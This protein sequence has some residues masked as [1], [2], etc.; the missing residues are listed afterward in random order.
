MHAARFRSLT[1]CVSRPLLSPPTAGRAA[2]RIGEI[3]GVEPCTLHRLLGYQPR[4]AADGGGGADGG[5][6]EG[7]AGAEEAGLG[8]Q[9]V[10]Q[11]N[12]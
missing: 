1:A 4:R 5:P 6:S 3:Q 8:T 10:F 11:Y 7:D 9:G 12:K 2:Q